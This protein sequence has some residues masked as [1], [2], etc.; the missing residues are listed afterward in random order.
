[1]SHP[2]SAPSEPEKGGKVYHGLLSKRTNNQAFM[3][4]LS[5]SQIN[6]QASQP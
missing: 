5:D 6:Y 3:P 1:M 2:A 4:L